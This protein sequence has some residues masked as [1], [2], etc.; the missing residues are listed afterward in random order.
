MLPGRPS[1][2]PWH[3]WARVRWLAWAIT[4]FPA[5]E[6]PNPWVVVAKPWVVPHYVRQ[7]S[8]APF[9]SRLPNVT[10][11]GSTKVVTGLPAAREAILDR[12]VNIA[13]LEILTMQF[14][15]GECARAFMRKAA[16][17]LSAGSR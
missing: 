12:Q 11:H 10:S 7:K 3:F 9:V 4:T 14:S 5:I 16:A 17:I 13:F 2:R 6:P 15:A 8:A 1:G